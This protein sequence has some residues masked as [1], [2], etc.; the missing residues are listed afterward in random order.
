MRPHLER[1]GRFDPARRRARMRAAFDPAAFRLIEAEGRMAG[2]VA[3]LDH[4]DHRE[5]HSFYIEPAA[6]GR[7]LGRAVLDAILAEQPARP[8]RL[9]VLK[10][11]PA[12]RF[13]E[14]AGFRL[15]HESAFDLHYEHPGVGAAVRGA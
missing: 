4:P 7:G 9:E 1:V 12:A 10:E 6:Q 2:C 5:I 11:S 14:R 8:V 15:T 13:Y 3:V